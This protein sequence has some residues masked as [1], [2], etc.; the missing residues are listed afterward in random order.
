MYEETKCNIWKLWGSISPYV[1]H[2]RINVIHNAF[3]IVGQVVCMRMHYLW[4][5]LSV[6]C[7]PVP[8]IALMINYVLWNNWVIILIISKL[9]RH[10]CQRSSH[11]QILNQNCCYNIRLAIQWCDVF[12]LQIIDFQISLKYVYLFNSSSTFKLAVALIE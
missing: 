10:D 6:S 8:Q 3:I 1:M 11:Y 9:S 7:W 12:S 2:I 5:V 4:K